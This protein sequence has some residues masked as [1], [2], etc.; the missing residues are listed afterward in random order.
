VVAV[1]CALLVNPENLGI[2]SQL[3]HYCSLT[4]KE[5][6]NEWAQKSGCEAPQLLKVHTGGTEDG[7]DM[8]AF[9]SF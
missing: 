1:K 4:I 2:R 8:I 9:D 7:I 6:H 5:P 3:T